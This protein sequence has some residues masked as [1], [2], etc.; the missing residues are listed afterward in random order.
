M[1]KKEE[2]M[3]A[4]VALGENVVVRQ[5]ITVVENKIILQ[6]KEAESRNKVNFE[7]VNV[8]K[9]ARN[10][11]ISP[12]D[13]PVFSKHMTPL[14]VA[15]ETTPDKKGNGSM[16]IVVHFQQIIGKETK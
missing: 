7:V 9:E 13:I 16:F 5:T 14:S 8:G 12:G 2:K 3:K 1:A 6:G 15:A 4:P 10:H 11:G